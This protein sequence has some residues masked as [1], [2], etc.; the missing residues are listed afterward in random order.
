MD[1]KIQ[2][3]EKRHQSAIEE[4][5]KEVAGAKKLVEDLRVSSTKGLRDKVEEVK[6]ETQKSQ[7]AIQARLDGLQK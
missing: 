5:K 7:A 6:K 3:L 2:E 1:Q 4:A